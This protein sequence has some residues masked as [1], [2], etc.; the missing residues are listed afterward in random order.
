MPYKNIDPNLWGPSLWNFLHYLSL[1]YPENPTTDEQ[2]IVYNFLASTQKIIPCEKCRKNF[3]KHLDAMEVEVLTSRTNFVRWLYN[4]HNLVN[5]D[6]GKPNF[7]YDEFIK[8][9]SQEKEINQENKIVGVN[10]ELNVEY[11]DIIAKNRNLENI[12]LTLNQE[13]K[14]LQNRKSGFEYFN[15]SSNTIIIGLILLVIIIIVIINRKN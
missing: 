15:L 13:I 9:Y 4:V 7:S 1:A 10:G 11:F 8:K 14:T 12:V 2:E 6:T 3:L 5:K